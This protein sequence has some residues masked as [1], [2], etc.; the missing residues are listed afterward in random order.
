MKTIRELEELPFDELEILLNEYFK[1][2]FKPKNQVIKEDR[3]YFEKIKSV[4]ISKHDEYLD[5]LPC[6]ICTDPNV[7]AYNILHKFSS[8]M[9]K[10]KKNICNDHKSTL[11]QKTLE[12]MNKRN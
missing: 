4:F 12:F 10:I 5:T 8:N 1:K 9:E 2:C 6:M 3:E 7:T 11:A